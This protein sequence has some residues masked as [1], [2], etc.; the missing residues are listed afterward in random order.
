MYNPYK[1][2]LTAKAFLKMSIKDQYNSCVR[3]FKVK[4]ALLEIMDDYDVYSTED[5]R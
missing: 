3:Y 4:E 1:K 2:F 5:T